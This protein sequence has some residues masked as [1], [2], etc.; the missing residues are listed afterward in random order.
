MN[1][2]TSSESI[3]RYSFRTSCLTLQH[4]GSD[5]KILLMTFL[6]LGK[7]FLFTHILT[8]FRFYIGEMFSQ[9]DWWVITSNCCSLFFAWYLWIRKIRTDQ[10]WNGELG[11]QGGSSLICR[12]SQKIPLR[13]WQFGICGFLFVLFWFTIHSTKLLL[14]TNHTTS[15]LHARSV[16]FLGDSIPQKMTNELQFTAARIRL[17]MWRQ[18]ANWEGTEENVL[19]RNPHDRISIIYLKF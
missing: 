8:S 11:R 6:K 9:D 3:V 17:V 10:C 15:G 13:L 12:T 7:S 1:Y 4:N 18:Q 14:H 16:R 2:K 5:I 19:N